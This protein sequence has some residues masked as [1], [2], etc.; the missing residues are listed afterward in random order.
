[1]PTIWAGI[2]TQAQHVDLDFYDRLYDDGATL[3]THRRHLERWHG[4]Q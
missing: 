1:M 4:A 3:E 2:Y